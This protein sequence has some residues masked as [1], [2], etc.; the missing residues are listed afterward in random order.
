MVVV[1][2]S[3]A[4]GRS[5]GMHWVVR[6]SCNL[7]VTV[8]ENFDLGEVL[9]VLKFSSAVLIAVLLL[10]LEAAVTVRMLAVLVRVRRMTPVV[11]LQGLAALATTTTITVLLLLRVP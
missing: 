3:I 7:W 2:A 11:R 9:L 4:S 10:L 1:V 8:I 5:V 6:E